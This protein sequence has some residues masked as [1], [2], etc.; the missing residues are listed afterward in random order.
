M[1]SKENKALLRQFLE[2]YDQNWGKSVDYLDKWFTDDFKVHFNA[3]T[4]DSAASP[5]V[6]TKN[7]KTIGIETDTPTRATV[8]KLL[9]GCRPDRR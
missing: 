6:V 4:M 3:E 1:N 8:Q 2:E 5:Q 9:P 7:K